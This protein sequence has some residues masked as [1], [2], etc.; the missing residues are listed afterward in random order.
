MEDVGNSVGCGA[1]RVRVSTGR[2]YV[3][4]FMVSVGLVAACVGFAAYSCN[5]GGPVIHGRPAPPQTLLGWGVLFAWPL[6]TAL[7]WRFTSTVAVVGGD[8][9]SLER[10]G[11]IASSRTQVN[12]NFKARNLTSR[13]RFP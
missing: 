1:M 3:N 8:G 6:L 13:P 10:A 12:K 2:G 4:F 9:V 7:A 11:T 5:A